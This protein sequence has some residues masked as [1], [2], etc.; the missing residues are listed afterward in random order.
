MCARSCLCLCLRLLPARAPVRMCVWMCVWMCV[1]VCVCV[2]VCTDATQPW[3]VARM[4]K[5]A[6]K[7][8]KKAG[9]ITAMKINVG[10]DLTKWRAKV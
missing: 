10:A 8:E 4:E 3:Q 9:G 7:H 1:C 5:K 2:C 6:K